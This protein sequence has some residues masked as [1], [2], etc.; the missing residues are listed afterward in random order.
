MAGTEHLTK[1][2]TSK[3]GSKL[4]APATD[5]LKGMQ[6]DMRSKIVY[7]REKKRMKSREC[8]IDHWS[9]NCRTASRANR[10]PLRW[11]DEPYGHEQ[12][13]KLMDDSVI[14]VRVAKLA[15]I[16]HMIG[17][18]FGIEHIYPTPMLEMEGYKELLAMPGVFVLTWDNCEYGEPYVHRQC[19]ITNMWFLVKLNRDCSNKITIAQGGT[20]HIH[21][22]IAPQS[23]PGL[24][25][26][27]VAA[28]AAG[29]CKSYAD[30]TH[31]WVR[32]PSR[33]RCVICASLIPG[34]KEDT[35]VS[36]EDY[37]SSRISNILP[38]HPDLVPVITRQ[39]GHG[40]SK[41]FQD[42]KSNFEPIRM[43]KAE[44]DGSGVVFR[45]SVS[46]PTVFIRKDSKAKA[47]RTTTEGG[48]SWKEVIRRVTKD[49]DSGETLADERKSQLPKDY[50][51]HKLLDK[52]RNIETHLY[53]LKKGTG[54]K[55]DSEPLCKSSSKKAHFKGTRPSS[56]RASSKFPHNKKR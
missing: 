23:G 31:D 19:Y 56:R 30:L 45:R 2:M 34:T 26:G 47:F 51:W 32:A 48:P 14:M 39:G 35:K 10:Y 4:I 21:L 55:F 28:F 24:K 33:E 18:F 40:I 50:D 52:V 5:I 17:D 29:W 44:Y 42:M 13:P 37:M 22:P 16:K 9:P 15:M 36:I 8:L 3:F 6:F 54:G 41:T 43:V 49:T 25:S 7:E 38:D 12:V 11:K 20:P 1:A 27:D 53:Y 46:N